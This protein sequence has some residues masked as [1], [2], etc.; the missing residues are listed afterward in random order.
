MSLVVEFLAGADVE[1]Q[2]IFSRFEDFREGFGVEFLI[3]VDAYLARLAVFPE[4]APVY[5]ENVRRQVIQRFPYG[6]FYEHYPNTNLDRCHSRF[7]A[8]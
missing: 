1:L 2:E 6:I 7:A 8:G 5:F 4:I 3:V